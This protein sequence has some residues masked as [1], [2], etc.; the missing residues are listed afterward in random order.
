VLYNGLHLSYN[1]D[2][3]IYRASMSMAHGLDQCEVSVTIPL[4]PVE[5]WRATAIDTEVDDTVKQTA[6]V[7]LTSLCGSR[8]VDT[9]A[10]PITLFPMSA[11]P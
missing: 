9:V 1:G 4:N 5:P 2:V 7:T 10:M 6:Q 8:L 11:A 3:P